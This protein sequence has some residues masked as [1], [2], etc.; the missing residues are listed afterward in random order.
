MPKA[1]I[2]WQ[3]D[4]LRGAL[5]CDRIC[6][7]SGLGLVLGKAETAEAD[8]LQESV[9]SRARSCGLALLGSHPSLLTDVCQ[10]GPEHLHELLSA[11]GI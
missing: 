2:V 4:A 6:C 10:W 3:D 7:D 11:T 8:G 9:T 5:C 1:S